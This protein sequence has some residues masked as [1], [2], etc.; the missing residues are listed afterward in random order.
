MAYICGF[1][2]EGAVIYIYYRMYDFILQKRN[3]VV[4]I[5]TS[6]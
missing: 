5:R 1:S 3:F 2:V 4:A 6:P